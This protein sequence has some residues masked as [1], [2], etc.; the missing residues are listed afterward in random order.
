MYVAALGIHLTL[1]RA[2]SSRMTTERQQREADRK[3]DA[4]TQPEF[5]SGRRLKGLSEMPTRKDLSRHKVDRAT[6]VSQNKKPS[7]TKR[8]MNGPMIVR[9]FVMALI[10]VA[11]GSVA[12]VCKFYAPLRYHDWEVRYGIGPWQEMSE[13]EECQ[14]NFVEMIEQ[15]EWRMR[16]R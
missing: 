16:E 13:T 3:L 10:V 8:Q 9:G 4:L 2:Y 14:Q 12:A 11:Y 7:K 6:C 5:K 1:L 15:G